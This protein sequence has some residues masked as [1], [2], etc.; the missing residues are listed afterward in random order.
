MGTLKFEEKISGTRVTGS[1]S[2]FLF[3]DQYITLNEVIATVKTQEAMN[4]ILD[5][6]RFTKGTVK[7][8]GTFGWYATMD[9]DTMHKLYIIENL[10][11]EKAQLIEYFGE[12]WM[13]YYIRFNH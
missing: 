1:E 7:E 9:G 12:H 4:W 13:D 2:K 5:E 11:D 8:D 3:K 6:I 10:P